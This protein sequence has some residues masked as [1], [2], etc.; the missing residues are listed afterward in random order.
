MQR[1]HRI[2][3]FITDAINNG[4]LAISIGFLVLML[5][6]VIFQIVA[7]YGIN[8]A[9]AWTEE[10]ARYAMIWCGL[11]GGVAAFSADLDPSVVSVTQSSPRLRQRLKLWA[12]LVCVV[13]FLGPLAWFSVGFVER[14]SLRTSEALNWNFAAVAVVL[15]V[16][17]LL[18][19]LQSVLKAVEFELRPFAESAASPG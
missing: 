3:R 11:F 6:L 12:T 13:L 2:V 16:Y 15:P 5:A 1:I 18:V 14:A 17:C 19:L 4:V 8:N 9:P 7:R 10:A